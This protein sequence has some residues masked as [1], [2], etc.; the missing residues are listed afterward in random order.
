MVVCRSIVR[1]DA[2]PASGQSIV[3]V[4]QMSREV[5]PQGMQIMKIEIRKHKRE[6]LQLSCRIDDVINIQ[7][8]RDRPLR[9][10]YLTFISC[11]SH[12]LTYFRL[13]IQPSNVQASMRFSLPPTAKPTA[14]RSR[15]LGQAW[16]AIWFCICTDNH[17]GSEADDSKHLDAMLR[18]VDGL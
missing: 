9:H 15:R 11:L 2:M 12:D 7:T 18:V 13:E 14:N 5:E 1:L 6:S 16:A 17:S 4:L 10:L 3:E 8:M